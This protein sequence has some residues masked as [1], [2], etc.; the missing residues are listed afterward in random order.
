MSSNDDYALPTYYQCTVDIYSTAI[1]QY[2]NISTTNGHFNDFIDTLYH[3]SKI[4]F[5]DI[6]LTLSI[7]TLLTVSRYVI[8][9]SI[10]KVCYMSI[11]T[12]LYQYCMP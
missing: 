10:Y 3:F 8:S 7:A 5:L 9:R 2:N 12:L 6:Y 4:S 11:Y 1:K